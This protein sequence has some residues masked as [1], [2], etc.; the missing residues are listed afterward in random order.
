[1]KVKAVLSY[2]GAKFFGS[3]IQP[4]KKTVFGEIDKALK[5]LNISTH[6]VPSGRTDRGVHATN[7][8]CHF[9]VPNFWNDLEKLKT[10][11]NNI[12][13]NDI[14]IKLLNKA[15]DDFH[16]RFDAKKRCYRYIISTKKPNPFE[17]D[18]VTFLDN[19]DFV[20][21][22]QNIKIFE[23]KHDFVYFCKTGSDVNSTICTIYKTIAY[24]YKD[25]IVLYFEGDRFLR[26]QIRM[27]VSVLLN[28]D[29]NQ[30]KSMLNLKQKNIISAIEKKMNMK[31]LL[32]RRI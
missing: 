31:K 22:K 7:Q 10:S 26:S 1:M 11:L 29:E 21:I 12:L 19:V 15:Y 20:K 30:I 24:K 5:I 16:A 9:E 3:Q 2:N 8:V 23:G 14:Y 28:L 17:S 25:Y 32:Y 6:I 27:M 18:F 4:D 13:E